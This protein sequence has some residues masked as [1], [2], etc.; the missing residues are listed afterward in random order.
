MQIPSFAFLLAAALAVQCALLAVHA[1]EEPAGSGSAPSPGAQIEQTPETNLNDG[2]VADEQAAASPSGTGK[3]AQAIGSGAVVAVVRIEGMIYGFTLESLKRRIDRARREGSEIIVLDMKT[4]GGVLDTSLKISKYLKSLDE[5]TVAWI[6][7]EAYSAGI[8]VASACNEIVMARHSATGDCAPIS[9]GGSL[10]PRE[11]KKALGPLLAEFRDNARTNNYPDVLF[12][13]MCMEGVKV[14]RLR[15]KEGGR[16]RYV[17]EKDFH[18]MVNGISTLDPRQSES[19]TSALEQDAVTEHIA[20]SVTAAAERSA[21]VLDEDPGKSKPIVYDGATFMTVTD[22]EAMELGLAGAIVNDLVE[23]KKHLSAGSVTRFCPTWSEGLA[24]WLTHPVVRGVLMMAL[25]VGTYME[26]QSPGLGFPGAVAALA[27]IALIVAPH[28]VGLAEV[29][30][31]ALFFIG[32]LLLAI[33]LFVTVGF[34]LFGLFGLLFMVVGLILSIVPAQG[35]GPMPLPAPEM[36]DRLLQSALWM[37]LSIIGSFVGFY[38]LTKYFGSIPFLNRLILTVQGTAPGGA[39]VA[40]AAGSGSEAL[41][42]GTVTIGAEGRV[43]SFLRPVGQAQ[44]D[45]M[46]VDVISAGDWIEVGKRVRVTEV[47]GNRIVVEGA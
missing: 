45:G 23:L 17:N 11:V 21:W 46:T 1:Q 4:P 38:Y 47:L 36:F 6:N 37:M 15:Q 41:G 14:Y 18:F 19:E 3:L 32:L 9:M 26:F 29:W 16:I 33:E 34:G 25:L 43:V 7:D 24:G 39:A 20:Q 42:A 5:M 40:M 8:L 22:S 44:I 27:L 31:A 10:G 13:A 12:Q 2:A 28:I 30:H 35:P